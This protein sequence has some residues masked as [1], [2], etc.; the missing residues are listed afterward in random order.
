MRPRRRRPRGFEGKQVPIRG[1][2][3]PGTRAERVAGGPNSPAGRHG[4]CIGGKSGILQQ[5]LACGAPPDRAAQRK[6]QLRTKEAIIF[7]AGWAVE[8]GIRLYVLLQQQCGNGAIMKQALAGVHATAR[9]LPRRPVPR[10]GIEEG[11]L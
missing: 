2:D 11:V 3:N 9:H 1:G 7:D 4:F 10:F 8:R 6:Q 5:I